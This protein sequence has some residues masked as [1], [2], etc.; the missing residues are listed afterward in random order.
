L[1]QSLFTAA[2]RFVALV[3]QPSAVHLARQPE[4]PISSVLTSFFK[5]TAPPL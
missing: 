3:E 4:H 5:S 1:Y 2:Q